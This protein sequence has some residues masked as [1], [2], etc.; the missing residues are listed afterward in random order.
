MHSPLQRTAGRQI[1]AALANGDVFAQPQTTTPSQPQSPAALQ[2][3]TPTLSVDDR[4]TLAFWRDPNI[5]ALV[6][7][8]YGGNFN[9]PLGGINLLRVN[10]VLSN[11]FNLNQAGVIFEHAP[12][13][14]ER[15]RVGARLD[16]IFG[17]A[18]ESFQGSAVNE[19]RPQAYRHIWQA[20]GSYVAPLGT[21]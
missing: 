7:T 10:D 13:V 3:Q 17:Q 11:S 16:L 19:L 14:E 15:R 1:V 2:P 6:D 12:K 8:Y 18:T 20:F 21:G 4:D 5:N 9:R